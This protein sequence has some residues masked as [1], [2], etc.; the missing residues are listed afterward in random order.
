MKDKFQETYQQH[1]SRFEVQHEEEASKSLQGNSSQQEVLV[2]L[3]HNLKSLHPSHD[4]QWSHLINS[5]AF[6]LRI[7]SC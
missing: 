5:D 2:V 1:C 6:L 7:L 3:L 4:S